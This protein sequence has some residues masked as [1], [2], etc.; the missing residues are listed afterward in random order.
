M[1][2]YLYIFVMAIVT[3]AI[4]S[5]PFTLFRKKLTSKFFIKFFDFIPYAVLGAMTVPWIFDCGK[6][7]VCAL[8]GLVCGVVFAYFE[9]PLIVVAFVSCLS[10][11]V[12][13]FIF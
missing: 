3:F 5:V 10:A 6:N 2:T 1:R 13:G 11:F 8:F 7:E 4:R 12:S 9:K